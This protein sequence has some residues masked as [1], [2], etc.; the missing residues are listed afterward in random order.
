MNLNGV[1]L[2]ESV[3]S[4]DGLNEIVEVVVYSNEY[5]LVAMSLKIAAGS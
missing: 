1:F 4:V 3:C 2:L 5:V